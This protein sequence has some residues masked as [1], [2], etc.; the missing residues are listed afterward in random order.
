MITKQEIDA[1]LA[2]AQCGSIS[3]ASEQLFITQPALSRRIAC[4]EANMGCTLFDRG[5]GVRGVS[6]TTRGE[7]FVPIARKWLDVYN[8]A[9]AVKDLDNKPSLRISAVGSVRSF[10]LPSI[11]REA[12]RDEAPYLVSFNLCH[13]AEAPKIVESGASDVALVDL[14]RNS[15]LVSETVVAAPV[16]SVPFVLI[17]GPQW[18]GRNCV[19]AD[20]LDPRREIRLPWDY[21]FDI[22]HE[23]YFDEGLAPIVRLDSAAVIENVLRDDLFC[24]VPRTEALRICRI[25]EGVAMAELVDGPPDETIHCLTSLA[26]GKSEKIAYFMDLLGRH[27]RNA[28]GIHSFM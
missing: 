9:L 12:T 14:A 24:I 16:Y 2:V 13:S 3:A 23:K 18:Q 17:G 19:Y 11:L 8:E 26:S 15:N 22:W 25:G 1:F 21:S 10:L 28:E 6:L 27:V 5:K 20:E 7:A 4:I